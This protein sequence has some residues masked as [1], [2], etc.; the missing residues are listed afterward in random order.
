MK[1]IAS[2]LRKQ[3]VKTTLVVLMF[4]F[5]LMVGTLFTSTLRAI[6]RGVLPPELLFIELSLRSVDVLSILIPLS[7]YLGL[8]VS[9]S[10]LYRNQEAVMIHSFGLSTKDMIRAFAPLVVLVFI[11]MLVIALVVSPRAAKIS[12]ELTSEA[13]EKISLMG[14]TEGKFQKFFSNEG[15]IFVEKI[16]PESKRVENI[17]ANI[18]HPDRVDTVTAEYGYQFEEKNQKYIALFNGYR[19]EGK[20][21]TKEYQMMKFDRNDIKLPDLDA[22]IAAL[23]EKSK[24]T[25]ELWRSKDVVEKAQLHWRLSPAF[26]VLVLFLLAMALAKTSHREAKFFNLVIGILGYVVMVNLLTIGHSLLEQGDINM[27]LGLW[28]VYL[29]VGIYAVWRIQRLDGPRIKMSKIGKSA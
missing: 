27:S 10:Q 29:V 22:E 4:L 23:D 6:A 18:Y 9:M 3:T 15:V 25:V 14:L 8:L 13:N 19:N 16:D 24:P 28:W 2:Y 21:G 12:K 7:F 17:F 20:P 5:L 26:S 11:V 1:I